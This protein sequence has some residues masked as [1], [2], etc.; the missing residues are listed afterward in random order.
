MTTEAPSKKLKLETERLVYEMMTA[1][2]VDLMLDLDSDPD[3]M[4]YINGGEPTS[5]KEMV[6]SQIPRL[7]RLSDY[8]KGWG[9]WKAYTKDSQ[10][11]IGW[12]MLKCLKNWPDEIEMGWRLKKKFWG[13]GYATEGALMLRDF[14]LDKEGITK[15]FATALPENLN[16]H[17]IM[18]KIGMSYSKTAIH[19]DPSFPKTVVYF[20]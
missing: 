18:A 5:R 1:S 13:K 7:E 6:E 9:Y 15:V 8:D 19:H 14:A 3:V 12:F 4:L 2:D 17:K 10:E 16:S 20:E 11:F